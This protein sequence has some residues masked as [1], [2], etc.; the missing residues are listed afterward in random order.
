MSLLDVVGPVM[1]GPSSSHTLGALR[2]ARFAYKFIGEMPESVNFVLHGSFADTW[3]GHGTDKA[4]LAGIMGMHPWDERIR[5]A[6][7]I[8]KNRNLRYKFTFD[9][10]GEV[11]PNTVLIDAVKNGKNYRIMGSSIGGGEIRITMIN[12][13]PCEISWEYNTML[14]VIRDVPGSLEK[15]LRDLSV[16]ISN[17]YLRRT[18]A[19]EKIATVIIETDEEVSLEDREK[20]SE[21]S[22][23]LECYYIRRD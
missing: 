23:V 2:I 7:T 1:V 18:N 9:D 11:H 4:L 10:L 22:C 16:N 14:V 13:V 5:E 20:V 12:E 3:K 8:A 17:L 21:N 15:I 6:H 19:L